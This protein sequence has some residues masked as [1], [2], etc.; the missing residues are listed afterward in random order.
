MGTCR[1]V[2]PLFCW[3][4]LIFYR[5][6]I[7]ENLKAA[8][9]V[10]DCQQAKKMIRRLKAECA[11]FARLSQ[12]IVFEMKLWG[13]QIRSA[14]GDVQTSKRGPESL[15]DS[16][17][18]EFTLEDAKRIRQQKGMDAERARKMISTWQSCDFVIQISDVSFKKL[19][20]EER[21]NRQKNKNQKKNI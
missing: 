6:P 11:D 14:D 12:D 4:C 18:T 5:T 9:G 19:T 10:I 8:T 13:D 17:P 7:I 21:E 16:L 20:V 1:K 2:C 3:L 15:L